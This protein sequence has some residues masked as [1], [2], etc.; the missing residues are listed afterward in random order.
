MKKD[1]SW[2]WLIL[3]LFTVLV[4]FL[5]E[6]WRAGVDAKAVIM[7]IAGVK[8]TLVAWWFMELRSASRVWA[9]GL[10][11][12]LVAILALPIFLG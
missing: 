8:F 3:I 6:W 10:F 1:L 2:V 4:F 11:A 5:G 9:V 12:L 7:V